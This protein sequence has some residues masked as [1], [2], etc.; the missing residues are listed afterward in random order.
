MIKLNNLQVKYRDFVALESIDLFIHNKEIFTI[1]GPSG[2]GKTTILR[3]I[4][5]F[6]NPAKGTV[7]ID[8]KTVNSILP[9]HRNVGY[10]FQNYALFPNM[11]VREN[12]LYGMQIKK[13]PKDVAKQKLGHISSLLRIEDCLNKRVDEL[14]GGQQQRV[15]LARILVLQPKVLLLDEPMSNIDKN[16]K[17]DLLNE[18]LEIQSRESITTI[19]VTHDYAEALAV[20]NRIAVMNHGIIEQVGTPIELFEKPISSHVAEC[21]GNTNK[22]DRSIIEYLNQSYMLKYDLNKNHFVR[23]SK[24]RQEKN[25]EH[26]VAVPCKIENVRFMGD[27]YLIKYSVFDTSLFGFEFNYFKSDI[28]NVYIDLGCVVSI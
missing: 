19:Y 13:T 20:S 9:Q 5:G 23:Y 27:Y 11:N 24:I 8:E 26:A 15:A 17:K 22:I 2:C 3:T 25:F 18:I 10:L 1:V 6:E 28:D 4:A 14:S 7:E 21:F 12:I 16:L